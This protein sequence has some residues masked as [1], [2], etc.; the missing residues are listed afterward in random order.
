MST[1]GTVKHKEQV[2][3]WY[4]NKIRIMD[5]LWIVILGF[6]YSLGFQTDNQNIP[7]HTY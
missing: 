6:E 5:N 2:K 1:L 7:L 3:Q 4:E